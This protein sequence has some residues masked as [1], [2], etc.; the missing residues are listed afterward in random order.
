MAT[1]KIP[2]TEEWTMSAGPGGLPRWTVTGLCTDDNTTRKTLEDGSCERVKL[3]PLIN[4]R[5][6]VALS[7]NGQKLNSFTINPSG[8]FPI[9]YVVKLGPVIFEP[10]VGIQPAGSDYAGYQIVRYSITYQQ[11]KWNHLVTV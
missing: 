7:L 4:R 1:G 8:T 10:Y 9:T 5:E 11:T 6:L 2:D 3:V